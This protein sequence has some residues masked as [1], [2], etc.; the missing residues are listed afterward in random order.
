VG[1]DGKPGTEDKTGMEGKA[2]ITGANLE[3]SF[4]GANIGAIVSGTGTLTIK[5]YGIY[6]FGKDIG[7]WGISGTTIILDD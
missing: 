4:V 1:T 2:Q 7:K 6:I 5:G 3:V